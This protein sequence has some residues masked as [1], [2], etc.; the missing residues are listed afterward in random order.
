MLP[1]VEC[2]LRRSWVVLPAHILLMAGLNMLS[3][4]RYLPM[5]V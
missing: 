3:F 5:R 1:K 2:A 4:W